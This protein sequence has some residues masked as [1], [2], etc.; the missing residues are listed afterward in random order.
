M[1]LG[2]ESKRVAIQLKGNYRVEGSGFPFA[3]MTV[4]NISHTG[5]C[6]QSDQKIEPG[7]YVDLNIVFE[8]RGQIILFAKVVWSNQVY[9]AEVFSTGVQIMNRDTAGAEKFKSFYESQLLYPPRS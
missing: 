2:R 4:V 8:N 7:K 5:I 6:F 1:G 3:V 9:G